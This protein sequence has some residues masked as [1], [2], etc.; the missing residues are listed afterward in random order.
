MMSRFFA[1][2]VIAQLDVLRIWKTLLLCSMRPA[3][4]HGTCPGWP[5]RSP[6]PVVDIFASSTSHFNVISLDHMKMM[7]NN[8]IVGS[9]GHF[10]KE[11]D[12]DGSEGVKGKKIHNIKLRVI[13]LF[14]P[15]VTGVIGLPQAYKNEVY[16]LSKE[17]NEKVMKLHFP[18]LGAMLTVLTQEQ[19]N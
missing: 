13:I 4:V 7:K 10:D 18:V 3:G 8:A 15:L 16:L 11:T 12:L 17:L 5:L 9:A 6:C 19:Q 1:H 14:S 2:L